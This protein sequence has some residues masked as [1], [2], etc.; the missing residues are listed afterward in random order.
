MYLVFGIFSGVVGTT[1]SIMIKFEMSTS[2]NQIINNGN[3]YNVVIAAHGLVMIFSS[4]SVG[5]LYLVVLV[6]IF[7]YLRRWF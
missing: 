6:T 4:S 2:G 7:A 1:F 3:I 5:L